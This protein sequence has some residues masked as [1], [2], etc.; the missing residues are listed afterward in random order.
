MKKLKWMQLFALG[1]FLTAEAATYQN[2]TA[3][4]GNCTET[5]GCYNGTRKKRTGTQTN[6]QSGGTSSCTSTECTYG[7]WQTESC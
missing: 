3:F 7:D 6:C 1:A 5:T 2:F 4:T